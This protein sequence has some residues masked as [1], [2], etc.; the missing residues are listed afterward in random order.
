MYVAFYFF[1]VA[2]YFRIKQQFKID[3]ISRLM[4]ELIKCKTNKKIISTDIIWSKFCI[5]NQKILVLFNELKGF[6]QFWSPYLTNYVVSYIIMICYMGYAFLFG[7]ADGYWRKSFYIFFSIEF[8]LM[9][10]LI[11]YECAVIV[12]RNVKIYKINRRFAYLYSET[13]TP[14]TTKL[15]RVKLVFYEGFLCFTLKIFIRS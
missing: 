14:P 3:K 13:A 15:L 12:Y 8:F 2:R 1:L 5:I 6:S 10:L 11:T 9:I 7:R 4:D